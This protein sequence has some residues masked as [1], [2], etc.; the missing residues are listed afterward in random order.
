VLKGSGGKKHQFTI[1]D[2]FADKRC[3]QAVLDFL[4][5][6][7]VGRLVPAEADAGGRD[8]NVGAPGTP[9]EREEEGRAEAEEL[10]AAGELPL[11]LPTPFGM[12]FAEED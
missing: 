4:S 2:L 12:A 6:T 9:G 7:D 8:F 5:A 11:S 1:R 10:G 3:S